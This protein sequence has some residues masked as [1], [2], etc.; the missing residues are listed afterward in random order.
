MRRAAYLTES[1]RGDQA[2]FARYDLRWRPDGRCAAIEAC[3]EAIE[4]QHLLANVRKVSDYIRKTC[5]VGPVTGVQG[6]GLLL[7]LRTT[8]PAKEIHAQLLDVGILAGTSTDPNILRLLPPF[9]LEEQH[10]DMLADALS[11]LP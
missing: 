8:K 3:I 4:S 6:E 11:H 10:V 7:G 2:G 1:V 9:I 5:I